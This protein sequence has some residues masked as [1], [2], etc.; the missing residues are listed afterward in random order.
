M[1]APGADHEPD[2]K[3]A[4]RTVADF[5]AS[6]RFVWSNDAQLHRREMLSPVLAYAMRNFNEVLRSR[7][8]F[9]NTSCA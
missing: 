4:R 9:S 3:M 7:D 1:N 6:R 5:E 8:I 2:G